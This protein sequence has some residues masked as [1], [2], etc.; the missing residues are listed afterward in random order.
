M[1]SFQ[2]TQLAFARH[3]R[4]PDEYPAPEGMED[5]RMGIYR[6]LVY[7]N[8]ESLIATVFPV[9]RS[10]LNDSIWH[11]MVRDFI[12]RHECKT[13]Y[14]LEISEEFLH[15][16]VQ[17]R[18]ICAD[19]P[20]FLL[21]LAHYEWIELALDVSED[22]LPAI[23]TLPADL[24]AARPCVSPLVALLAYQYPVHKVSPRFQPQ[25]MT[26][27]Q[28]LVYRNRADKVCFMEANP[29]TQRLLS[30]LQSQSLTLSDALVIIAAE[31]QHTEVDGFSSDAQTLIKDFYDLGVI[32]HFG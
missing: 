16:L 1:K 24:M 9:L 31:L 14:F 2:Q 12:H 30:L 22:T 28:L 4:A 26:P 15:Y 29:L 20:V 17:V 7:N 13:P 11:S 27:T 18:G 23:D 10:I 3:M 5:R 8:I 32:S 21:E 25:A 19:D 6:E